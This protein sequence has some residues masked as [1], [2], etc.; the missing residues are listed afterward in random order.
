[1]GHMSLQ[2]AFVGHQVGANST[3][4]WYGCQ[5]KLVAKRSCNDI[6]ARMTAGSQPVLDDKKQNQIFQGVETC[7]NH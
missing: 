7:R 6:I 2:Y 4:F 1:M 5:G 3:P